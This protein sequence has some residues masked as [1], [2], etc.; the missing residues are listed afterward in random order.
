M[1]F[2]LFKVKFTF[3]HKGTLIHKEV[4][5]DNTKLCSSGGVLQYKS[6]YFKRFKTKGFLLNTGVETKFE[7]Y[8]KKF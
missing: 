3:L 1:T 5:V 8:E 2:C 7:S 6:I 4:I